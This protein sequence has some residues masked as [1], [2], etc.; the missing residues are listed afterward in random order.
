MLTG[1]AYE[2]KDAE[3]KDNWK[4]VLDFDLVKF[5]LGDNYQ[6][7]FVEAFNVNTNLWVKKLVDRPTSLI[8]LINRFN[9]LFLQLH[10]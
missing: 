4:G 2:G 7:M 9:L 5:E 10:S 8:K 1:L 3:G 6:T